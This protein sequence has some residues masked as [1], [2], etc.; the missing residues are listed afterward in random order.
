MLDSDGICYG[1]RY[2]RKS[3]IA[4]D[5]CLWCYFWCS[6]ALGD[7]IVCLWCLT[8]MLFVVTG[9]TFDHHCLSLM[10]DFYA[11]CCNRR[12]FCKSLLAFDVW[13]WCQLWCSRAL[14]YFIV[15]LWC[16][17]LILF[18]VAWFDVWF[19]WY[20]W[21]FRAF[22]HFIVS[23]DACFWCYSSWSDVLLEVIACLWC[24]TFRLYVMFGST[25]VFYCM[26]SMVDIDAICGSWRYSWK[27]FRSIA[28][29]R[30]V[31][32]PSGS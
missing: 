15:G 30:L 8:L 24:L 26:P 28:V 7:F 29:S 16:L 5:A 2:F 6:R 27:S 32:G 10:L 12:Y 22:G 3:L 1:W 25:W 18:V 9:R 4:F 21:C 23:Y 19:W 13:F 20:M 31:L 11:I 14:D 17:T